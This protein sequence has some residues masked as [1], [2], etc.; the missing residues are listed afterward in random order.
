MK[1]LKALKERIQSVVT[2][3]DILS[4]EGVISGSLNEEQIHCPFHGEDNKKSSRYYSETD[5]TWCWVCHEK[6]DLFSYIG[7][8]NSLNFAEVLKYLVDTY[9]IDISDVPDALS[10]DPKIKVNHIEKGHTR[11]RYRYIS[12]LKDY[13][14]KRKDMI[15]PYKY[16]RLVYIYMV[17][18]NITTDEK[19]PEEAL[20]VN[21]AILRIEERIKNGK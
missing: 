13:I 20:K 11:D 2:L 21:Q 18:K 1:D 7:K 4:S 19:F 16:G 5:T 6:L 17:M 14:K 9:R 12:Q 8:K 15:D 10:V 3:K